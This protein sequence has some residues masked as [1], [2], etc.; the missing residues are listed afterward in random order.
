[1]AGEA[2]APF[3]LRPLWHHGKSQR[4]QLA[5]G[6]SADRLRGVRAPQRGLNRAGALGTVAHQ[7]ERIGCPPETSWRAWGPDGGPP[8]AGRF[9]VAHRRLADRPRPTEREAAENS[10]ISASRAGR[11]AQSSRPAWSAI[12]QGSPTGSDRPSG[13]SAGDPTVDAGTGGSRPSTRGPGVAGAQLAPFPRGGIRWYHRLHPAPRS[14]PGAE[15]EWTP[16]P[17]RTRSWAREPPQALR[18]AR[19]PLRPP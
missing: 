9:P 17:H 6:S 4:T 14:G 15:L 19:A 12:W 3:P 5:A 8:G 2:R 18:G 11:A 10:P 16:L 1:M 7:L 13:H